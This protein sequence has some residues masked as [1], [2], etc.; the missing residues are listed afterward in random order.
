MCLKEMFKDAD[1]KMCLQNMLKTHK[2]G[3]KAI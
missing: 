3:L 1:V 2:Y